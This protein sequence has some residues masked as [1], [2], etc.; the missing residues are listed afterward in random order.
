MI[1]RNVLVRYV[2]GRMPAVYAALGAFRRSR[3]SVAA[4]LQTPYGF[5][6]RG[7]KAMQIGDFEPAETAQI[8]KLLRRSE[9]FVNI[10][11][12]VGYYA[13]LARQCLE[14]VIAVEPLGDNIEL[15]KANMVLNGSEDIEVF[16]IGCGDS[17]T[18]LKLYGG[19]TGASFVPGWAGGHTDTYRLVPVNTLDNILGARFS[20]KKLLILI[21]VEG[22]ELQVLRGAV[23]QLSRKCP[24]DW[25]V[26]IS[27][28]EHQPR[29]GS[30]NANL[31]ETF[32]LFWTAGYTAERAGTEEGM[33]VTRADVA[34]WQ[35]GQ[36]LPGT[37][38]FLFRKGNSG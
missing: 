26:E 24:P 32:N 27:I 25:F 35:K 20:G 12:N 17:V 14:H 2:R 29:S 1:V 31:W 36:N 9:V 19:G 22:F 16:P 37:H 4:A 8:L 28:N 10:G 15:L 3:L 30:I 18:I 13:L 6:L 7:P 23:D 34:N 38:N 33:V 5:K 21:D 11:A